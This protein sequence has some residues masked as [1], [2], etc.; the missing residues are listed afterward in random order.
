MSRITTPEEFLGFRVGE[1]RKLAGWSDMVG[2][3]NCLDSESDRVIVEEIGRSTEGLPF[4]LCAISSPSNLS[5]MDDIREIQQS[6]ADPSSLGERDPAPLIGKA[7][8]VVAVTCSIDATEVGGSQMSL[9]LAYQ[10]ASSDTD[11]VRDI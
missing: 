1:D 10:L 8:T 11:R 5:R 4:I 2:Y 7:R 3:F 9:G 6:L